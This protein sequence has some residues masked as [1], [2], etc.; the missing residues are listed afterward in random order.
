MDFQKLQT[1]FTY[2]TLDD[3][4]ATGKAKLCINN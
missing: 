4:F 2:K 1:Q 3:S